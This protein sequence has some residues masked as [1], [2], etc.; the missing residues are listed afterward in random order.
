MLA[1]C[2]LV[3]SIGDMPPILFGELRRRDSADAA[4]GAVLVVVPPPV[5]QDLP[6]LAETDEPV[7]VQAL[8][9]QPPVEALDVGVLGR[10]ARIDQQ[11]PDVVSGRLGEKG[12]AREL[13]P[14]I[15][16]DRFRVAPEQGPPI[17]DARHVVARDSVVDRQ[18]HAFPAEVIDGGQRLELACVG[19]AVVDEVD[20]PDFVDRA[21]RRQ[22]RIPLIADTRTGVPE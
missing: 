2:W 22:L 17:Q 1:A 6:G 11:V 20:A 3:D 13:R 7:V 4:V 15:G 8:V 9:A 5:S 12:P 10:L 18:V 19:Q 16:A 14:A 21:G